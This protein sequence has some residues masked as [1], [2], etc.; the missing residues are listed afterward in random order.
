MTLPGIE[1]RMV[2]IDSVSNDIMN[3]GIRVGALITRHEKLK[4]NVMKFC[5]ARLSLLCWDRSWQK[6]R[7]TLRPT[8]CALL[9]CSICKDETFLIRLLIKFTGIYTYAY[10]CILHGGFAACRRCRPFLRM[11]SE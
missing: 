10:G 4:R 9:S 11:V 1:I 7:S 3:C 2:L 5:Q 6:R 8:T